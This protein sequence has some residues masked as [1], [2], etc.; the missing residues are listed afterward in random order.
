MFS[1]ILVHEYLV[2]SANRFPGKVALVFGEERMTYQTLN[3]HSDLLAR[4]MRAAGVKRHDRVVVFLDNSLESVIALYGILKA[5][6]TFVI[7]N[8]T[9]KAKKLAYILK[10]SGARCLITHVGKDK[11]VSEAIQ[12]LPSLENLVW[13]GDRGL[14]PEGLAPKSIPWKEAVPGEGGGQV[15]MPAG[16]GDGLGTIDQDLAALIY[17]SG[18]TGEPKGVMSSHQNM[19]SVARSIIQYLGNTSDDIIV[20]VLPLSF[21]YGLYQVLMS[22]M[23]GGTVVFESFLFPINVLKCIE[24]ESV[25][26][27]PLVPTV[28]AFLLRLQDLGKYDLR[29]LR[30]MTN[31]GAALPVEHIRRLRSL[32]PM[33]KLFSMFGL[34][35]CKRVCYLPPEEIDRRPSSVGKAIPNCEVF[36]V[37]DLGKEVHPGEVGELVVR[38]ANVMRGYWNSPELTARTYR[39]GAYPGEKWLCSGDYFRKDEEGY[40]YFLGRKDDMIKTKGE[41]VSPKELEN[42]LSELAGVSE[43]AVIGVPDEILGQAVAAYV[44]RSPGCPLAE[45]DVLGYCSKNLEMFMIPKYV[46]FLDEMPKSTNGKIDKTFLKELSLTKMTAANPARK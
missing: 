37:D 9:L 31:T 40:L 12:D 23:F 7:L 18:S 6:G 22:V 14:I 33:V 17:T 44:V 5:G 28:A 45:K 11:V 19:V 29:S 46:W 13:V 32:L 10:D 38:G 4:A 39:E 15:S 8:G 42:V 2:R 21:D 1:P 36:I 3:L 25:T 24:K 34:T 27:F 26:G 41:R 30:Y 35:E 20:N 16:K 43:A